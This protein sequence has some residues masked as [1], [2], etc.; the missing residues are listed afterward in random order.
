MLVIYVDDFK[1]AAPLKHEERLWKELQT[2]I[3]LD[4]PT[5]PDRFLGC[6]TRPFTCTVDKVADVLSMKPSLM[7]RGQENGK[8]LNG[9]GL[10]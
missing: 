10:H 5:P 8:F 4:D 2:V 6:Y 1:L 9:G 3:K 7:P